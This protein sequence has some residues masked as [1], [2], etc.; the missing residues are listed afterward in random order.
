[1]AGNLDSVFFTKYNE[2]C[3]ELKEAYPERRDKITFAKTLTNESKLARFKAEVLPTVT[4]SRDLEKCPGTV[5]PGVTIPDSIWADLSEGTQKAIQQYLTL[6][7]FCC[8][9]GTGTFD[10]KWA[11]EMLN[12][13]KDKLDGVD[14]SSFSQ[15]IMGMFASGGLPKMPERLLKGQLAKLA[16]ELVK[17]FT[18]EDFG[19]NSAEMAAAG[20]NPMRAFELL[21][22]VFTE[23]PEIMQNAM[24]RIAKRLQEKVQRGELRPQEMAK[25]AEELMKEFTDNPEMVSLMESFRGM[26]GFEDK[27]AAR[28]VGRDGENRLSIVQARLRKK[29]E[30]KKKQ[31]GGK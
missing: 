19:M 25:E 29:L 15:K 13:W 1:M 26:F 8:Q 17:E 27:E 22:K 18:P 4:P 24:K 28:A 30:E 6:L 14:F 7:S 23:R 12:G 31:R 9:A 20:D 3:E 2:F 21:S 10:A 16:E 5:L 11:E